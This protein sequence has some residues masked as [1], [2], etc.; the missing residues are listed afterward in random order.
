M[1]QVGGCFVWVTLLHCVMPGRFS[2]SFD[3]CS[4]GT[5][6]TLLNIKTSK[7]PTRFKWN[8]F[9]TDTLRNQPSLSFNQSKY[10]K[11]IRKNN[12]G[13]SL[14]ML[15]HLVNT[16]VL[17]LIYVSKVNLFF[18]CFCGARVGPRALCSLLKFC[19]Y[20]SLS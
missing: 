2:L 1:L 11:E 3:L 12:R 10:Y 6:V 17:Y 14:N 9:W 18:L 5:S 15:V 19:A 4:L 13:Q 7:N 16:R 8:Q 20:H